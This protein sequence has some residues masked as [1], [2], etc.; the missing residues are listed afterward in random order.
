MSQQ[1]MIL[2]PLDLRGLGDIS[3]LIHTLSFVIAGKHL[4]GLRD[5]SPLPSHMAALAPLIHTLFFVIAG[6]HLAALA[7]PRLRVRHLDAETRMKHIQLQGR[8]I[9]QR[10]LRDSWIIRDTYV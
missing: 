6:K 1:H 8:H 7:P 10:H 3:P 2:A 4:R 5:I 9:R